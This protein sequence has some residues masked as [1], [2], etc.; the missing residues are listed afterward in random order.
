MDLNKN[1]FKMFNSIKGLFLFR[2]KIKGA[3]IKDSSLY[4]TP[5]YPLNSSCF[6][7][8]PNEVKNFFYEEKKK[9][10]GVEVSFSIKS[11]KGTFILKDAHW[12]NDFYGEFLHFI[13]RERIEKI[14]NN[15]YR[16]V[17]LYLLFSIPLSL[18][19]IWEFNLPVYFKGIG[20]IA[21]LGTIVMFFYG[22]SEKK[23]F[24]KA[25]KYFY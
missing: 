20:Q 7:I 17:L 3:F 13:G 1:G 8:K 16:F 5:T 14:Q 24:D 23:K 19:A 4:L 25:L 12:G 15:S 22:T 9:G 6:E 18:T 10:L 21:L 2:G 11:T